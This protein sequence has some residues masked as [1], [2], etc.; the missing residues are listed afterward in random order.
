MSAA[1]NPNHDNKGQRTHHRH[2]PFLDSHQRQ[3]RRT[4]TA[5]VNGSKPTTTIIPSS[6]ATNVSGNNDEQCHSTSLMYEVLPSIVA[7][8]ITLSLPNFASPWGTPATA[9]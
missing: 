2:Y 6:T 7:S 4:Q 5:T 3:Q 9:I 1:T 8:F